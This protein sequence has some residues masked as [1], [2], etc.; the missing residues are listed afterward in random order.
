MAKK[1]SYAKRDFAGLREELVNLT[2]D[3]YPDLIKNTNDA[4]IYSVLLDLNAAIGDNLH[5]HI[6]RVW[7][8]TMLD[9]AQQRRSLFHIAKTYG[10]RIPGNR[11]SVSLCDFSINVPVRGDKEDER[12][13]GILKAGAQI[14]GGGQTFETIEDIDFSTPFNSKGE[15]NRL[16]IPN[17]DSNNKL[18]SYTITKRDAVV[19]GVSRVFRRV[20]GPQDQKPF[21]KIYLPEQNVLGVTSIIHK[22]GTNYN[23]NPTSSE[24]SSESNRWY[25]VKSLMEDK[26]FL[27]NKTSSSD[28][29]NFTAGDYKRVT[30]KFITEY[31][32]EGYMSVTFGSGSVDPLDNLDSF[33]DGSL[34]VN[35]ATYLNNLSL[36]ATPKTNST[37]FVK[38]RVGGGKNTNLGVNVITSVDN[39]EFNVTGPLTNVNNQVIQ[40]LNVTNVTPAVGG[41]DQPTIEE[42]RNMVG[43]NF[44]AQNRA[45]TLNDYKTLI[46]TMPSTYGA[47]AK[48]NVMEEDN[49]IRIK[50]LSYDDSGNLTDTVS[51]TLK[52]NILRYLTNYRMI[53]D[54]IDIVSG[55]VIDLGLEIDLLVD[56]NNNQTDILKD[57]ISSAS[58]H[59]SIDKRKMGDPLFVGELQ[60]TISEITGVV[61]VVDLRV[62]GKTGGEYSSAEVSQG[63]NDE[64]TKEISQSDSTIFMKSNQIYQV[65]FPNKDIKIRVKTLGSTTF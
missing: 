51:N 10:I 7:Q 61:N 47:P 57:V 17:F 44:A 24:F 21:F 50:L 36:G 41:A 39:V 45:V 49:K 15:P 58:E 19:N 38:Y 16:K 3:Y 43:Y 25:E 27:P 35:L 37:L 32:P 65:R 9:F 23:G 53:N 20:I 63:Y 6:D 8:E 40:S 54:Y 30:N 18:V 5:Y 29:S 59:F 60:K 12:Y 55:E 33:N 48:V 28:T 64:D 11:P 13:L 14:S 42:I 22:E 2:K 52:N 34:K 31:T 1:I 62:Y 26:V 56:K 46:E 4:S